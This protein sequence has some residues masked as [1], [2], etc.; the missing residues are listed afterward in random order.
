MR[1]HSLF[2]VL[3]G[4]L[5][6][7]LAYADIP[8]QISFQGRLTDASGKFVP[9]GN[10]SLTFRIYTDSTS[11]SSKWSEGQLISVSKGL[12][13]VILGTIN[14]IPDSIFNYKDTW[15]GIQVGVD[16]EMT[17]RQRLSSL[18]YAYRTAKADTSSY[19][20]NSDKL[21]GLHASDFTSPVSDY[22]RSGVAT[23][24]YEGTATLTDKYVNETQANS[25]TSAMITDNQIADADI[26]ASANITPSKISGTAWTSSNDG[27]GSGLDADLL[28]GQSSAAFLSTSSD[29]GRSGVTTN[30]YE[31]DS[32]LTSKY[33]NE[34]QANSITSGMITDGEIVDADISASASILPS[35]ISGTAWT[36]TNDGSGSGLDADLL[37]G[38]QG[39]FFTN[40]S[41]LTTGTLAD[42]RLSAN[43]TLLNSAQ[44]FSAV[45]AFNPSS[46]TVP[47]TVDAT[48]NS[49]VTNLNADLLDGQHSSAFVST[50]TDYGRSGVATDLYEGASTLTS[51]YINEVGPD[52]M[53]STSGTTL[54]LGGTGSSA[55]GMYG[56]RVYSQNNSSGDAVGGDFT[57]SSAGTGLHS[58]IRA[59][60]Y[61]STSLH[62][63]GVR[64]YAE[65]TSS[66]EIYGGDFEAASSGTG[67]HYGVRS[68]SYGSSASVAYGYYGLAENTSTGYAYGGYFE[69]S[70]NGTGIHYGLRANGSGSSANATYGIYGYAQNSSSGYARG[71]YFSTSSSGTGVHFGLDVNAAGSSS[72]PTYGV[73]GY[74]ENTSSGAVYGGLFNASSE[75]TGIHYGVRGTAYGNSSSAVYASYGYAQNA[76]NGDAY[77]GY[78]TTTSSGTGRHYGIGADAYSSSD[79]NTYGCD[80]Y[81]QNNSAGDVYGGYFQTN[82]VGTGY[83]YAVRGVG[84]GASATTTY[85]IVGSADNTSSGNI[86]GGQFYTSSSGTGDH[87]GI[88]TQGG[89]SSA[90]TTSYGIYSDAFNTSTATVYGGYFYA[91]DNGTGTKYGV[92]SYASTVEGYAGYFAGDMTATGTK[93]AAVKVDNSEY[94]LLYCQESPENWFEDFGEA[95]MVNGKAHI[96]LEPL[97]LQTVTIDVQ[98]PMK[99]FIQLR[100]DCKGTYVKTYS[101]GFDIFELQGGTS[102]A[103]FSYRVVA[104]RKGYENIRLAKMMGQTPEEMK[105]EQEQRR[106]EM[107]K[108]KAIIS[109]EEERQEPAEEE[110]PVK[111]EM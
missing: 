9:D 44:T 97:F 73:S 83:H 91:D 58:G 1:Y 30:L 40:A 24:L 88:R 90:T 59:Q 86:F 5:V 66:G 52:S 27:S 72:N 93:S 31:G 33:V 57:V 65:N 23:D 3:V 82:A 96:E 102:N 95:Q 20:M 104:K 21:D 56:L 94:R 68:L 79:S 80:F 99:V 110:P 29:Y 36:S 60:G 81:A 45:K 28:D 37:D 51:K 61:G 10:Y 55:S 109:I 43:V 42:G 107:E 76:S 39:S 6:C 12:F 13:N 25:V 41:N 19:S 4:L 14:S 49:T 16:P 108:E 47:F 100:D 71:G 87:Y 46:G 78:F 7:R 26:S 54:F 98:N 75:G 77:G 64:G 111:P 84:R 48:K 50:A 53:S 18:G 106:A 67:I 11:G 35:K 15:L 2:V 34:G 105:A 85:G 92:Y 70:S 63:T 32:T 22:G 62:T 89:G 101:T 17:P 103:A 8:R 69:T 38:Q 74:A